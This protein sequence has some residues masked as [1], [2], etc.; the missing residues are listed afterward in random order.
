VY[1]DGTLG[2]VFA[3]DNQFGIQQPAAVRDCFQN[4]GGAQVMQTLQR[5]GVADDRWRLTAEAS[6]ATYLP[7][8]REDDTWGKYAFTLMPQW[9]KTRWADCTMQPA[10]VYYLGKACFLT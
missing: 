8:Q 5:W 3:L 4:G 10:K 1:P 9:V 2:T 6:F 7:C